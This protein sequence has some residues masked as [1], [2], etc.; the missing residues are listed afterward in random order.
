M[1]PMVDSRVAGPKPPGIITLREIRQQP[2]VWSAT[3]E[4]I[5]SLPFLAKLVGRPAIVCGAGSSA[6][7]AA[8]V[9]RAWSNARAIPTTDLL[10]QSREELASIFPGFVQSGVLVSLARSG[11][12]PE[13]VGVIA[14]FQ[15]LFPDV[16]HLAITCNEEGQ[17]ARMPGIESIV[18]DPRTNDHSLVMTG[19]FSNLVLAGLAFG[20]WQSL[21]PRLPQISA[22]TIHLIPELEILAQQLAA[23]K[24]SRVA[25]LT[26]PALTPL[27]QE[28]CLKILEMTGGRVVAL[29]ETYLGLRHGPMSF[30]TA[31]TLVLCVLSSDQQRRPYELDLIRELREKG[32]GCLVLVGFLDSGNH[33]IDYV[34]P[35]VAPEMTD[36]LRTPFEIVFLQFLGYYLSLGLDLDPDN[37]SPNGVITRVVRKFQLHD[38]DISRTDKTTG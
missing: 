30:L 9:A 31:D 38:Y 7:A 32:L 10:V 6:Y 27:A 18:L 35:A 11:E 16:M 8:S 4:R 12:S 37:P 3:L 1:N 25:V 15:K 17:L 23:R 13:S 19:S 24:P 14:R 5:A 28:A 29:P 33:L 34:V 36:E 26:S 2:D 21:T 22:N 20:H